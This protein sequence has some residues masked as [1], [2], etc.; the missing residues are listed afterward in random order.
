MGPGP[1]GRHRQIHAGQGTAS[2]PCLTLPLGSD[3]LRPLMHSVHAADKHHIYNSSAQAGRV[4][5]FE[6]P[7]KTIACVPFC[8]PW[9]GAQGRRAVLCG[10]SWTLWA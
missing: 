10:G 5:T 6:R 2:N 9:R 1:P 3:P 8:R 4:D 7:L